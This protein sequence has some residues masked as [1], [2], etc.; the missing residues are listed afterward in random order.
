MTNPDVASRF[1][2][3]YSLTSK[4]VLAYI[5]TKCRQT[6]DIHDIFQ[7]SYLEL[8]QVLNYRGVSYV[9]N[10]KAFMLRLAKRKISRYYTL[11]ERLKLFVSLTAEN[12]ESTP[13]EVADIAI[14]S[15]LT[16]DFT[17]NQV[18][19][20]SAKKYISSKSESVRKVFYLFYDFDMTI[21]EISKALGISE[22]NVKNKLYRTIKELRDLL[23]ERG[24]MDYEG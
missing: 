15:I 23:S 8:F 19:V 17:I 1:E 20:E 3:I 21:P 11:L 12:E 7:D 13:Y 5:T 9:K 6:A 10:P 16:E 18:L 2:E 14:T 24:S 4:A 22:S